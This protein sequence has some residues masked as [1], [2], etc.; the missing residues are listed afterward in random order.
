MLNWVSVCDRLPPID[1][2]VLTV[3]FFE[4]TP[5]EYML[6]SRWSCEP[7]GSNWH[8]SPSAVYGDCEA[9]I[10]PTHWV[11]LSDILSIIGYEKRHTD[12]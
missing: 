4:E 3:E 10:E 12:S 9:G 2:V 6:A 11:A 5:Y 8:W 7:D 1:D